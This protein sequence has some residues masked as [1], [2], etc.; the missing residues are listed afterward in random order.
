MSVWNVSIA[1]ISVFQGCVSKLTRIAYAV[2]FWQ[3]PDPT[4][5][6]RFIQKRTKGE[7]FY[8]KQEQNKYIIILMTTYIIQKVTRTT[9]RDYKPFMSK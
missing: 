6:G 1:T 7:N 9:A 4:G 8:L 5:D 3:A 2:F